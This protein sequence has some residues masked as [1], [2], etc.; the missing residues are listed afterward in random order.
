MAFSTECTYRA[1]GKLLLTAEYFVL[2]GAQALALPT[3][4]GQSLRVSPLQEQKGH[5]YWESKSPDGQVWFKATIDLRQLDCLETNAPAI[6]DRL[7]QILQAI[8]HL[9]PGFLPPGQSLRVVTLLEFPREWGLGTSSTLIATFA[10][11]AGVDPYA[12][13]QATFGGS[14]YDIAC[15][16]AQGPIFYQN[17]PAGPRVTNSHFH[18]DFHHQLFFTYLGQK[19]NSRE[20]IAHYRNR[21]Q[22]KAPFIQQITALSQA[23]AASK[24]LAEFAQLLEQH[25]AIVGDFIQLRPLKEERFSDYWGAV[26]SLGAWGG[27]FALLTS[28]RSAKETRAYCNEKGLEVF[29]AYKD[30]IL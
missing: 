5:L 21:N 9:H 1:H 7:R 2:D 15:A 17:L 22:D 16:N 30:L 8:R 10:Q 29:Y 12:L 28:D 27:D 3:R 14:G 19:Q 24:T 25:E 13:L 18:P 11:W 4:L 6:S 23:I 26:K 20:G